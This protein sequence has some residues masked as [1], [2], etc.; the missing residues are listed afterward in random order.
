[1][2]RTVAV[3]TAAVLALGLTIVGAAAPASALG[4]PITLCHAKAADTASVGWVALPPLDSHAIFTPGP[5]GHDEHVGDIIP[6]FDDYPG[7]NLDTLYGWGATGAEILANGCALPEQPPTEVVPPSASMI[8]ECGTENDLI[9]I[10]ADGTGYS[11]SGT[12]GDVYLTA[13]P[14]YV[15]PVGTVTE[16]HFVLTDVPCVTPPGELVAPVPGYTDAV[17]DAPAALSLPGFDN[18]TWSWG[19]ESGAS[20][21]GEPANLVV[22]VP[23]EVTAVADD[24]FIIP[25]QTVWSFTPVEPDD[26]GGVDD[27]VTV[28]VPPVTMDDACDPDNEVVNTPEPLEGV[29]FSQERSGTTVTVTATAATG[30]VLSYE[31][32]ETDSVRWDFEVN[33]EACLVVVDDPPVEPPVVEPPVVEPPVVAPPVVKPPVVIPPAVI[34]AAVVTARPLAL[35]TT[36]VEADSV[37]ILALLLFLVGAVVFSVGRK[38]AAITPSGETRLPSRHA[39]HGHLSLSERWAHRASGGARAGT[40]HRH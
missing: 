1:M 3:F 36:G 11:F 21:S 37:G 12:G 30:V 13:A 5:S 10:P 18:G 16:W 24:G 32:E 33:D 29:T 40:V 14:T 35:A 22:G 2:K 27:S 17:C 31:G 6:A 20:F 15:F 34:P 26:C 38:Q 4:Q 19:G 39:D 28:V 7:K 25:G 23:Y 8:D 9:V